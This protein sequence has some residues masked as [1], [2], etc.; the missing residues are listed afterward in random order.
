M[1]LHERIAKQ[2]GWSV[3]ETQ[4]FSLS[5][6]RELVRGK[7]AKLDYLID[8]EI[9]SGSH[10]RG[11]RRNM[12]GGSTI[13]QQVLRTR[14]AGECEF[15][16]GHLVRLTVP[17]MRNLGL[18]VERDGVVVAVRE[19]HPYGYAFV[20]WNTGDVAQISCFHIEPV[21]AHR[22]KGYPID[23]R[24]IGHVGEGLVKAYQKKYAKKLREAGYEIPKAGRGRKSSNPAGYWDYGMAQ[25]GQLRASNPR[26]DDESINKIAKMLRSHYPNRRTLYILSRSWHDYGFTPNQVKH[27]I[28]VG[29]MQP[30]KAAE[31]RL[32]QDIAKGAKANPVVERETLEGYV[33]SDTKH[34]TDANGKTVAT[35]V[36]ATRVD[37]PRRS[38]VH[39][40]SLL[41]IT[42]VDS[43]RT[44]WYGRGSP[45]IFIRLYKKKD[46]NPSV[47]PRSAASA[48]A[49]ATG[50]RAHTKS[51][52]RIEKTCG[53]QAPHTHTAS[54]RFSQ[55]GVDARMRRLKK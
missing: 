27:Y 43:H 13:T 40:K 9:R 25:R 6:L 33:S 23:A 16:P 39:G 18:H 3:E 54:T 17:A 19:G 8:Q 2:L 31:L 20:F 41:A 5:Q 1:T 49:C 42:A 46:T 26:E 15:K 21:P 12:S 36:S 32:K 51:R 37:L 55:M 10:I 28:D 48:A 7:S 50:M 14:N 4:R 24:G 52:R 11:T 29:I 44:K 53:K 38:Y 34:I 22:V 47:P 30:A 45:G 35:V